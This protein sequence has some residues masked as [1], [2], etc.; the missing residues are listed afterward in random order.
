MDGWELSHIL[1]RCSAPNLCLKG[2]S[3]YCMSSLSCTHFV[4]VMLLSG[5]TFCFSFQCSLSAYVLIWIGD[6]ACVGKK[7]SFPV[8]VGTCGFLISQESWDVDQYIT[9]RGGQFLWQG[10]GEKIVLKQ[11]LPRS[12]KCRLRFFFSGV[13]FMAL[14]LESA[15]K[16]LETFIFL[17]FVAA[18]GVV[19][20]W[21]AR[22]DKRCTKTAWWKFDLGRLLLLSVSRRKWNHSIQTIM[23]TSPSADQQ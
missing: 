10:R 12:A 19:L 1:L 23:Q 20:W 7:S 8:F 17:C 9:T 15:I 14:F 22:Y 3:C 21:F 2:G 5:H 18:V 6:K 16:C 13:R 4:L 11:F